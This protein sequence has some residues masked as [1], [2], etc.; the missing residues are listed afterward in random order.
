MQG[1]GGFVVETKVTNDAVKGDAYYVLIQ[2]V[3]VAEGA[4]CTRVMTS[5]KVK[6]SS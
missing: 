5:F 1:P 2:T 4:H 6:I 3:G